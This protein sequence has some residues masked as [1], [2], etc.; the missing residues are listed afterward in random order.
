MAACLVIA[1]VTA[2]L[3]VFAAANDWPR[4]VTTA[5][6]VV[7]LWL[8]WLLS[9]CA[10]FALRARGSDDG[11]GGG[12][13]DEPEPPWWPE[14]ERRLRDHSRPGPRVPAGRAY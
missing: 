8:A 10:F 4:E 3:G 5:S 12:G 9:L 14:F 2:D 6:V 13:R 11:G 7:L 1:A